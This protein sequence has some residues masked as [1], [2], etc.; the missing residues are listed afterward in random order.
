MFREE[1]A[2]GGALVKRMRATAAAHENS[3]HAD[4]DAIRIETN[5]GTACGGEDAAPVGISAGQGGLHERRRGDGASDLTGGA[6]CRR[7]AD[8]DF[9]D[10]LGAFAIGDDLQGERTA[11]GFERGEES[12]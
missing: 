8:F 9:N 7:T 5:A 2:M 11:H 4:F 6:I 12:L 1:A 3:A 10:A